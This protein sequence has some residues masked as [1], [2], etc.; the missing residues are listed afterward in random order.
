MV[1]GTPDRQ[2]E[3]SNPGENEPRIPMSPEGDPWSP[4]RQ[5]A[6]MNSPTPR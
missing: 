4:T 1:A 5:T 2:A 3:S 6:G